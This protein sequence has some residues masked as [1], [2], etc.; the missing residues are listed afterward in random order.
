MKWPTREEKGGRCCGSRGDSAWR[1][2]DRICVPFESTNL[3]G[4][5]GVRNLASIIFEWELKTEAGFRSSALETAYH[6]EPIVY[7]AGRK[8]VGLAWMEGWL[9]FGAGRRRITRPNL[10]EVLRKY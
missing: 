9:G 5:L 2:G 6:A 10:E 3:R 4:Q 8:D 1:K 7:S